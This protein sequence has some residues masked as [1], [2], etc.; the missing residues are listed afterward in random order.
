MTDGLLDF[1]TFHLRLST[2]LK[3]E[4]AKILSLQDEMSPCLLKIEEFLFGTR[5]LRCPFMADYYK[6][7]ESELYSAV[8]KMTVSSLDTYLKILTSDN[9]CCSIKAILRATDILLEPDPSSI[10][11]GSLH[12]VRGKFYNFAFFDKSS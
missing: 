6:H 1:S 12:I 7:W 11:E 3:D 10:V 9:V 4:Y 5:T 2:V 8:V